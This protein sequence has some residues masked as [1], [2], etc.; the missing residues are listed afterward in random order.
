M[1]EKNYQTSLYQQGEQIK[2]KNR[3]LKLENFH[4]QYLLYFI[5]KHKLKVKVVIF[6][7]FFLVILEIILPLFSYGYISKFS[8][9]LVRKKMPL[10]IVLLTSGVIIYIVCSFI[11]L[12]IEK[13]LI[14]YLL[15]DLRRKWFKI[16]LTKPF[17]KIK[18]RDKASLIAK[19][20]YHFPLLQMGVDRSVIGLVRWILYSLGLITITFF[21]NTKLLIIVLA[22]IPINLFIILIGYFVSKYYITKETTL[23]SE[24]IKDIVLDLYELPFIQSHRLEEKSL[25]KLDDLVKLDTYFRIRRN[26]WLG[27]G[28]RIIFASLIFLAGIFY[29]T[30]TYFPSFFAKM[31]IDNL[32]LSGIIV[33]YLSRL[34]YTSLQI[35]LY[36]LPTK[37]GL[38]LS[39]PKPT[40][41]KSKSSIKS[42]Q[43]IT[44]QSKKTK[45][46]KF[47]K[48]LHQ[49]KF[50]FKK[51]E[52]IL[53]FGENPNKNQLGFIFSGQGRF[54]TPSWIVKVNNQRFFYQHW[55]QTFSCAYFIQNNFSTEKKIGE[56][57]TGKNKEDI[58][59]MD[60]KNIF[61]II[62]PYQDFDFVMSL[63]K[64]I[65]SDFH[66]TK[67]N[68]I[69]LFFLQAAYCLIN[70]PAL[71][72]ID[73]VYVNLNNEKINRVLKIL[74][75]QLKE[76]VFVFLSDQENCLIKYDKKYLVAEKEIKEI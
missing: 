23:Y 8:A 75:D 42:F 17:F 50:D 51:G 71:I 31:E 49:I 30:Q 3:N 1:E 46:T 68:F 13:T 67:I 53:I 52:K 41:D 47:D 37:L 61:R 32:F 25:K 54:N 56:I 35:G 57:L 24:I 59:L 4:F 63:N 73:N 66:Q 12:K 18:S 2:Q 39:I 15:N 19:I 55:R 58:T 22:S 69:D 40:P 9:L 29:I 60:I 26:L 28:G 20:S 21:Y 74:T 62:S 36:F 48:Y 7:I 64:F 65:G 70:R 5:K 33:L 6:L 34:L 10:I 11:S 76:S 44:F 16:F 14:V 72:I 27:F 43:T 38:I 45:L